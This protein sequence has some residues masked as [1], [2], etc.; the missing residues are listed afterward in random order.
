MISVTGSGVPKMGAATTAITAAGM[1][2]FFIAVIIMLRGRLRPNAL[3]QPQP[4]GY[5]APRKPRSSE[6]PQAAENGT[7]GGCWL[8][9][10]G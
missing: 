8:E 3:P 1:A 5:Q 9:G 4:P 2:A 10:A 6:S 7:G